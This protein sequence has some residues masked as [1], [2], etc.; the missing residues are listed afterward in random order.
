[1]YTFSRLVQCVGF[2]QVTYNDFQAGSAEYGG[3]Q[4]HDLPQQSVMIANHR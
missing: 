2:L 4:I 3:L 1:M